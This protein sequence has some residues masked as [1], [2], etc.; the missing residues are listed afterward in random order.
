MNTLAVIRQQHFCSL[1]YLDGIAR[2][3]DGFEI[4]YSTGKKVVAVPPKPLHMAADIRK[5]AQA[6][7]LRHGPGDISRHPHHAGGRP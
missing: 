1:C 2:L 6:H 5:A 3:C 4:I 7:I